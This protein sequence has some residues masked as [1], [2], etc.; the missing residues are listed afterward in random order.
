L[1][2]IFFVGGFNVS[3]AEVEQVL[4]RHPGIAE[5][6]VIGVPDERLGEVARA[7]AVPRLDAAPATGE[8]V[9]AWARERLA[10]FKVP[11]VVEFVTTLPRNASGKVLKG[12]LR[13]A[14]RDQPA[15]Q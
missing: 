15:A 1:K 4:A 2:D 7:Y 8:A 13:A 10:N 9:I 11:R 5:V 12:E 14:V 3:P 6:V